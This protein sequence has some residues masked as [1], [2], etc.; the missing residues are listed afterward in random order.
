MDPAP[1]TPTPEHRN[2]S[3][4]AQQIFENKTAWFFT[5]RCAHG[6]HYP[7]GT[8]NQRTDSEQVGGGNEANKYHYEADH[9]SPKV[10]LLFYATHIL[11]QAYPKNKDLL[12]D[13]PKSVVL[14]RVPSRIEG[15]DE[16]VITGKS[17]SLDDRLEMVPYRLTQR[18]NSDLVKSLMD[19]IKEN[20]NSFNEVFRIFFPGMDS[21]KENYD[22]LYR[23][24][25]DKLIL[26]EPEQV[27]ELAEQ[28]PAQP[29]WQA[30]KFDDPEIHKNEAQEFL[31]K[32]QPKVLLTPTGVGTVED[33]TPIKARIRATYNR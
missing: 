3:E 25:A 9:Y 7:D 18:V 5:G 29:S 33:F 32:I 1:T 16:I 11:D 28:Y 6:T 14:A 31:A 12:V 30:G 2:A 4:I 13:D 24:I 27:K 21:S 22:G 17:A 15:E 8:S 19:A 26:L 20:P 23:L 10:P